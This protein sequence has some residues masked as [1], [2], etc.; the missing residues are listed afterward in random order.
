[1]NNL[2]QIYMSGNG[3]EKDEQEAVKWWRKAAETDFA[4][5]K[6]RL[7]RCYEDGIGVEKNEK[8]RCGNR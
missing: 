2:A 8:E 4:V 1:M 3:V 5:A 6:Y 7:G